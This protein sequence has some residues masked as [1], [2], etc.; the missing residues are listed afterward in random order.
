MSRF[1]RNDPAVLAA[2]IEWLGRGL[3]LVDG[4]P[5]AGK[6]HLGKEMAARIRCGVIDGDALVVRKQDQFIGALKADALRERIETS[7]AATSLVVL[8]T[9]CAREVVKKVGVPAAAFVWIERTS[10]TIIDIAVRDFADD[11]LADEPLADDALRQEV[12]AYIK[13][14]DAR[15]RVYFNA[16]PDPCE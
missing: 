12:E 13:A 10:M 14:H 6:T 9:V 8:S 11:F 1:I 7:L 4:R 5:T 3:I 16:P 15:G 2:Y